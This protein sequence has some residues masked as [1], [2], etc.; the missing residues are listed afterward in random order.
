MNLH[1][2]IVP[3][4]Q[5]GTYSGVGTGGGGQLSRNCPPLSL[6]LQLRGPGPP[7]TASYSTEV[8][9]VSVCNGVPDCMV[10]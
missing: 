1:I 7:T 8:H 5:R 6:P 4:E 3:S 10:P 2:E 9:D